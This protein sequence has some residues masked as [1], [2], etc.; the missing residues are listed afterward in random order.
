MNRS[1]HSYLDHRP[2]LRAKE[3]KRTQLQFV[4]A[5]LGPALLYAESFDVPLP[6]HMPRNAPSTL[7]SG[8]GSP[9]YG[10]LVCE[11]IVHL[12][13]GA[14]QNDHSIY[15]YNETDHSYAF[16][17]LSRNNSRV[18]TPKLTSDDK[19]GTCSREFED[20]GKKIRFRTIN[21]FTTPTTVTYRAEYSE[22]GTHWTLMSEGTNTKK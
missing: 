6:S 4:R 22:D 1:G 16:Y 13:D 7:P 21:D 14:T 15:T 19:R 11:Q 12:L 20:N 10:F 5:E 8:I 3:S 2:Q 9:N 17:G 18:R